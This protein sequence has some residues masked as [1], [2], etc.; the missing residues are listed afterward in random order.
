MH[1]PRSRPALSRAAACISLLATAAAVHAEERV[2]YVDD[3]AAPG[4]DGLAW[5]SAFQSL[6]EALNH[7]NAHP[8]LSGEWYSIR[9]AQGVY[10]PGSTRDATFTILSGTTVTGGFAGIRALDPDEHD[11][12]RFVTVLSGDLSGDDLPG[13]VNRSDNAYHVVTFGCPYGGGFVRHCTVR[14]GHADGQGSNGIGGAAFACWDGYYWGFDS[15]RLTDN[16]A[17]QGGAIGV[18]SGFAY[19]RDCIIDGNRALESGGA[20]FACSTYFV[21]C[22]FLGNEVVGDSG[23]GGAIHIL[24]GTATLSGCVVSGNHASSAGGGIATLGGVLRL[25]HC[26]F[27]NNSSGEG[28]AAFIDSSYSLIE[29]S[30]FDGAGAQFVARRPLSIDLHRSIVNGGIEVGAVLSAAA[31]GVWTVLDAS[32]RFADPQGLDGIAGTLDDDLQLAPNSIAIDAGLAAAPWYL[33]HD[34]AWSF[35]VSGAPRFHNDPAMP[36]IGIGWRTDIDIGAY[37]FQGTSCRADHDGDTAISVPDIFSY[38]SDWF[39]QRLESDFDRD[40][41]VE[42]DDLFQWLAAWFA[43]C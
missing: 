1:A 20:V 41:S 31:I 28:A 23:I 19:L 29:S 15:C 6:I 43:G 2:R 18:T 42:V 27:A 10:T 35:D 9:V 16:F 11:P 12:S 33:E 7:A 37:E 36:D 32:P 24:A 38:L 17:V 40:R 4:G 3:D 21:S 8:H 14:G 39:A 5:S 26:S 34:L 13:F 22:R 30:A 25:G